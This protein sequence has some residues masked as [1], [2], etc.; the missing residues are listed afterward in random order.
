MRQAGA[1]FLDAFL[2]SLVTLWAGVT[3]DALPD[4]RFVGQALAAAVIAGIVG[5][6]T[7]VRAL[8]QD[9]E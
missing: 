4:I 5:V 2:G 8:L 9:V 7:Y 3:V 6:M 1:A